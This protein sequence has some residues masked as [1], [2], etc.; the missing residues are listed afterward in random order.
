MFKILQKIKYSKPESSIKR[1]TLQSLTSYIG[2]DQALRICAPA[3]FY[4]LLKKYGYIN[5]TER[6]YFCSVLEKGDLL[7]DT[8]NWSRPA[9]SRWLRRRYGAQIVSWQ[10][11]P[12]K[13]TDIT[14][15][16]AAGYIES[17]R[18]EE[19]FKNCVQSKSVQEIVG[20]GYPV[21]V[22][23][24]PGFGTPE[25]Q[26][27]HAVV[28]TEWTDKIVTIIDSD[29]RNS[30]TQF[31]P[32]YVEKYLSRDGAGSVVLPLSRY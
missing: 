1:V 27:I 25:N 13:P 24:Q 18:E 7:T 2:T 29:A 19:F 14:L 30:I 10:L 15:M 11:N 4:M 17:E 32:Y 21:I 23:M 9:L 28:I 12:T 8:S 22:T 26:S 6:E 16:R 31:E 20:L 5:K 3:A